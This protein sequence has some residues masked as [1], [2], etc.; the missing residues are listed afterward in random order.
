MRHLRKG[1]KFGRVANQRRALT[2]SMASSFFMSG[3][4][5]TT[6][7][8]AR[9]MRPIVEKFLTRAKS[10]TL[11][12][13]RYL[14]AYFKPNVVS[15]ILIMGQSTGTRPGGYTR[16]VK[17]GTRTRDSARLAILEMVK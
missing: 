9:E 4:I 7:A 12:T 11:A 3:S 5:C 16:M 1:R 17:L 10:P 15:R 6:E 8:K 2:K 13:R 14:H